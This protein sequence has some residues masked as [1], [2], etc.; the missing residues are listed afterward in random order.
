MGA[1]IPDKDLA[2]DGREDKPHIT[3][4]Y[5]L[6]GEDPEA[7]RKLLAKEPPVTVKLGKTS[8]FPNG[9]SENGDVVKVDVD[10]P[11]LHKLNKKI[12]NAMPHTDT[13]PEYKPHVTIAYVRP[14]LGKRYEGNASLEGHTMTFD[15]L[16]F[17]AKDG[18]K[19]E[20]VLGGKPKAVSQKKQG[21][22]LR[23]PTWD[24]AKKDLTLDATAEMDEVRSAARTAG[25]DGLVVNGEHIDLRKPKEP[26]HESARV[27]SGGLRDNF[28]TVKN[29][30]LIKE[31]F[32]MLGAD[33]PSDSIRAIY[34]TVEADVSGTQYGVKIQAA[35]RKGKGPSEQ[36]KALHRME[37]KKGVAGRI[38]RILNAR[39]LTD[40]QITHRYA[41]LL[42]LEAERAAEVEGQN[43]EDH[44]DTSFEFGEEG[45]TNEHG[46]GAGRAVAEAEGAKPPAE[47][48]AGRSAADAGSRAGKGTP[49]SEAEPSEVA[50]QGPGATM[51]DIVAKM[52]SRSSEP[53][54]NGYDQAV[55]DLW[56][57]A[58]TN[59]RLELLDQW[60][61]LYP[62][63]DF[64]PE[65]ADRAAEDLPQHVRDQIGMERV[66]Q[67]YPT[68]S[69]A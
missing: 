15:R 45:Y 40:E 47:S 50:P 11:E 64:F 60:R 42:E 23:S 66:R 62:E 7:V 33:D 17:S 26:V 31:M 56:K 52:R 12:A 18:T 13:H 21:N 54:R 36:A 67:A 68:S 41:E 32:A 48:G 35:T 5:G 10:S 43:D 20:I 14:G 61:R 69:S 39:G 34:R 24:D 59:G 53:E 27:P 38:E 65:W 6:H 58:G 57:E 1:T 8:F 37:L 63:Q 19:H 22:V 9:E 51:D 2:P 49:T 25:F 46:E 28:E 4:K 3:V 44:G 55:H 16:T 30:G 29:D